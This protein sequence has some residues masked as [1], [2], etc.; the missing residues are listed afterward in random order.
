MDHIA[1]AEEQIVS[2]RIRRKLEEVNASAQS[3]LSPIQDHINFTLQQAYFKC[4]YECFDRRRTQEEIANCVEHCSVPVVKSQQY[5]ES[6]M[7][8]FQERMN[9]SLMVC[10]DKFEASKL[11]KNRVDAAKDMEGC[12]NQSIQDNLDTLP[13]LVQRMKTAF[14]IRD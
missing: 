3:Q 9:R 6:E 4:A 1:A 7:A 10:Q 8:Q 13:H 2:E 14:S 12:V 5:F 11:H